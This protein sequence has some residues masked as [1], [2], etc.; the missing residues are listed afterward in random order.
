M[1]KEVKSAEVFLWGSKIGILYKPSDSPICKF[2]YDKNFLDSKIELSPFAMPLSSNVYE[3]RT[4]NDETFHGLPGL[5]ADSL[6]DRFGNA[7]INKW[8]AMNGRLPDS[9]NPIEMLCYVGKRGMGALEYI[10]AIDIFDDEKSKVDIEDLSKYASQV[11][12][13]KSK[14]SF[15]MKNISAMQLLKLGTSAGGARAKAIIAYNKKTKEIRSGQISAGKGFDYYI[16]KFDGVEGSGDHGL[17]D[18]LDYTKIEYAYYNMA[19]DC[20]ID[21]MEC[22]LLHV[23]NKNHFLTK[24][25]DRININDGTNRKVDKVHMQTLGALTHIDYNVPLMCSYEMLAMYSCKLNAD[26]SDIE[27]IYRR[28]VFNVLAVNCDDH[29]KNFSFLMNRNGEWKLSPA[30]DITFAYKEG[31]KWLS[32][33][34]MSV[35]NKSE[36]INNDDLIEAGINMDLKK[37]KCKN[38]V[39]EIARIT[40]NWL[41]YAENANVSEQT[42]YAINNIIK[43]ASKI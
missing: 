13:E 10:P 43:K 22:E 12:N 35:N 2:M 41:S 40:Q 16:L 29:V 31:N 9:L 6:P 11:L 24:R 1:N 26:L 5:F 21:M 32:R 8:L 27:Q 36:N 33:H 4:L 37:S 7:V 30:Y 14:I 39:D 42:A 34:Q 28:M 19:I 15:N 17:K 3:F 18:G 20:K 25:F 23:G 38:I